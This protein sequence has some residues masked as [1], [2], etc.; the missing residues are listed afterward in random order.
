MSSTTTHHLDSCWA[1]C[2]VV[3][4]IVYEPQTRFRALHENPVY[5]DIFRSI[6]FFLGHRVYYTTVYFHNGQQLD[7]AAIYSLVQ[8]CF[9]H[10][11]KL[12]KNS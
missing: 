4:R 5:F 12:L 10:S 6:S 3:E 9:V 2:D 8:M 7:E 1:R 11:E